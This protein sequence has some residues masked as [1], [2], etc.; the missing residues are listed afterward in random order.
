MMIDSIE[1]V[2]YT[3]LSLIFILA[4][5]THTEK[6][7]SSWLHASNMLSFVCYVHLLYL[8]MHEN[9]NSINSHWRPKQISCGSMNSIQLHTWTNTIESEC[10]LFNAFKF[11]ASDRLLVLLLLLLL[12]LML[13]LLMVLCYYKPS[14]PFY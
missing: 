3:S 13:M 14:T 6:K 10:I 1:C 11:D 9:L 2:V 7:L 12:M 8:C 4:V 5:Y